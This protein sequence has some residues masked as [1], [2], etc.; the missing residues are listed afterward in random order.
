MNAMMFISGYGYEEEFKSWDSDG[1][2]G[3]GWKNVRSYFAKSRSFLDNAGLML[4][5]PTIPLPMNDLVLESALELG[6]NL[7]DRKLEKGA[8]YTFN[9]DD[10]KGEGFTYQLATMSNGRRMS[11]GRTYLA[12]AKNRTNLKV[13]KQ[14]HVKKI[15]LKGNNAQSVTFTYENGKEVTVRARKEIILSA[16]ALSTPQL[17]LLSGVGPKDHL[18]KMKI[19]LKK[20]LPVGQNLQDHVIIPMYFKM[21]SSEKKQKPGDH[22]DEEDLFNYLFH[23]NGPLSSP[24]ESLAALINTNPS[25]NNSYPDIALFYYQTD[26]ESISLGLKPGSEPLNVKETD[27]ILKVLV[28]LIHPSSRGHLELKTNNFKDLPKI[29]PNYYSESSDLETLVRGLKFQLSF[30]NTTPFLDKESEFVILNLPECKNLEFKSE[31]YLRCY[32]RSM[33]TSMSHS[34]GTNK[35]GDDLQSVVDH[36]L[37]VKGIEGLRVIDNSIIPTTII[38]NINAAAV[39]IGEKG[40]DLLI[41]EW[42]TKI[43]FEL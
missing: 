21:K 15:N 24:K 23:N 38:P 28:C 27:D 5:Y 41:E 43:K 32:I 1:S 6:Y 12:A 37:K 40:S 8:S 2:K 31:E 19:P 26:K 10:H 7:F 30:E 11:T 18:K 17:L 4:N 34:V 42:N 3:W 22:K 20:D 13:V 36:Q 25:S 16:G 9:L 14:A 39:M 33:T 35:M 29:V